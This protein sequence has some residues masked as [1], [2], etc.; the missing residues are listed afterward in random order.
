[1][2]RIAADVRE[3]SAAI[4]AA[5]LDVPEGSEAAEFFES[6]FYEIEWLLG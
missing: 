1:M 3:W 5:V 4:A 6:W 2:P